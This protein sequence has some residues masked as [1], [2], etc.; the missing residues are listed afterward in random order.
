MGLQ[1]LAP[2]ALPRP[3]AISYLKLTH[4]TTDHGTILRLF[5]L[6]EAGLSHVVWTAAALYF[7]L[8]DNNHSTDVDEHLA[9]LRRPSMGH[10]VAAL[11]AL[12]RHL[13]SEDDWWLELQ[14]Q[15]RRPSPDSRGRAQVGTVLNELV[16]LRNRA[17][18]QTLGQ[19]KVPA[20]LVCVADALDDTLD[21]LGVTT[22]PPPMLVS[23][24]EVAPS[25]ASAR[26][27]AA[28]QTSFSV[29]MIPVAGTGRQPPSTRALPLPLNKGSIYQELPSGRWVL[30]YPFMQ[31]RENEDRCLTLGGFCGRKLTL[32]DC[33]DGTKERA[34][35]D[36]Q[37]AL[38]LAPLF[39]EPRSSNAVEPAAK[40]NGAGGYP[41]SAPN[42]PPL[43]EALRGSRGG[44]RPP[45][46]ASFGHPGASDSY[47]VVPQILGGRYRILECLGSGACGKVY[48]GLHCTTEQASAIKILNME[49]SQNPA[50]RARFEREAR[51]LA[52][53]EHNGI[54]Q[55]RDFGEDSG[56]LYLVMEYMSGGTLAARLETGGPLP[57]REALHLMAT[58]A[59]ALAFAHSSQVV[60]RDLKPANLLFSRL[61]EVKVGDFGLA[62]IR[63]ADTKSS[64]GLVVGTPHY[65][66]PEQIMGYPVDGGADI[67]ALG[68]ILHEVLTG[69]PPFQGASAFAVQQQHLN[70]PPPSLRV[71]LPGVSMELEELI[72]R[73]MAKNPEV[74]FRS[75]EELAAFI[76]GILARSTTASSVPSPLS[77]VPRGGFVG[78]GNRIAPDGSAFASAPRSSSTFTSTHPAQSA[79]MSA[80]GAGAA[81]GFVFCKNQADS[82][83]RLTDLH[84]RATSHIKATRFSDRAIQ[85]RSRYW[86]AVLDRSHDPEIT[87]YRLTSI[88]SRVALASV[89]NIA[90]QM[91]GSGSFYLGLTR[92]THPFEIILRDG[93][94]VV[95]CFHKGDFVVY[96][97]LAFDGEEDPPTQRIVTLYEEMFDRLWEAAP[98]AINFR[99][100]VNGDPEKLKQV[101][102]EIRA[103]FEPLLDQDGC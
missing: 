59:R 31:T 46:Q 74:R 87:Y 21:A 51:T 22:L 34:E 88:R 56:L 27:G 90:E 24:C 28:Q 7:D 53:M 35:L 72:S 78:D 68:A 71:S 44:V 95:F 48:R 76:E 100:Q 99:Q 102:D 25:A 70:E 37:D 1:G 10:W 18:H 94:E 89:L 49:A 50:W 29:R 17:T 39:D 73:A 13:G 32:V 14:R 79:A 55:L 86:Q 96:A 98:M 20:L 52:R 69:R 5:K 67:Y 9:N 6:L 38:E 2:N 61:G 91:A 93:E 30:L 47:Q 63:D 60:H 54:V 58:I 80:P 97:S 11:L 45:V 23:S 42:P 66:S 81:P 83:K 84:Y 8:R 64:M 57:I 40:E 85:D 101:Q 43:N 3:L 15:V 16:A 77:P 33:Q 103:M 12:G 65:M 82:F 92:E 26:R 19:G 36:E 62:H 41:V 75:C 4:E